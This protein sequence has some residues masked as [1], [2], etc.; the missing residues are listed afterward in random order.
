MYVTG[1]LQGKSSSKFFCA[2]SLFP[3]NFS[4]ILEKM[5]VIPLVNSAFPSLPVI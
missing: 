4:F 3:E 1:Q 2:S 5:D